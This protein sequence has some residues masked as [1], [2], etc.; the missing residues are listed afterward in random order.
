MQANWLLTLAA[1]FMAVNAIAH[2][3]AYV[4]S[5]FA[6]PGLIL[7]AAAPLYAGLSYCL[8]RQWRWAAYLTFLIVLIGSI[9]AMAN[10]G[11]GLAPSWI[12][13]SI[14]WLDI[15]VATILCIRL[16]APKGAVAAH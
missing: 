1:W 15:G 7:L 3:V 5:G 12:M 4:V 9:V 13:W 11:G 10:T 6:L 2:F 16:W 8:L 14:F